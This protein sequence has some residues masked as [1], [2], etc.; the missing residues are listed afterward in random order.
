MNILKYFGKKFEYDGNINMK[1]F[2]IIPI[3]LYVSKSNIKA[4]SQKGGANL[5]T[6]H[7]TPFLAIGVVGRNKD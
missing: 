4:P 6:L 7:I 5:Y 2:I 1:V 3:L